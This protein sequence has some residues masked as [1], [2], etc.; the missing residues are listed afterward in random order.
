MKLGSRFARML[1]RT[2]EEDPIVTH[3]Q[4]RE[5]LNRMTNHPK[6]NGH[7]PGSKRPLDLLRRS[8]A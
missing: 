8:R 1:R 2:R 3:Q 5:A 7:V 4:Y 6:G